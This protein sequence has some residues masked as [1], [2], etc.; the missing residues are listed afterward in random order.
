MVGIAELEARIREVLR[1]E[2]AGD[3]DRIERTVHRILEFVS[4]FEQAA[5]EELERYRVTFAELAK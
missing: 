2:M 1:D 5:R 4:P 3:P